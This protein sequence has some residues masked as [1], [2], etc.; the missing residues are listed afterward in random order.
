VVQVAAHADGRE[1]VSEYDCLLLE[2]VFGDRPDDA[3]KASAKGVSNLL[4]S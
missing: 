4:L 3:A 2:Y 1:E